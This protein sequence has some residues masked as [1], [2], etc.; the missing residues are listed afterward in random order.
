[1]GTTPPR[2]LIA[3][4]QPDVLE[5]LRLLLK[6]EGYETEAVT[7]PGDVL[8]A[9]KARN[10]DL[11]LM[12]LNYARDTTSGQEGLD[13][14]S[15]VQA[16]DST[17]PVV[18]MT[19]WGSLEVAVEA[20]HR[21]VR[22]FVLKP[23]E[24]NR[25]LDTLRTQ[26]ENGY[27]AREKL[28][29]S[30]EQHQELED[31]LEIQRRLLPKQLPQIG[32]FQISAAWRPARAVSGD[33]FDA[34]KFD[35]SRLALCIA[36][37]SGKGMPAALLM[38]NLQAVVKAFASEAVSPSELC[39]RV[40][41]VVSSNTPDDRFITFLYCLLDSKRRRLTYS[42]AGHNPGIIA[43]GNGEILRLDRGGTV[44]GPFVRCKFEQGEIAVESGD[45]VLLFTDGV[46]EA[47]NEYGEEFGEDRLIGLLTEHR[48]L[49]ADDLQ[50]ALMQAVFEF[51]GGDFHDDATLIVCSVD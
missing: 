36:D 48:G 45:R 27:V 21:G 30:A 41:R 29:R 33:Y 6:G 4:D 1:M 43:R 38:S 8:E 13:L 40:N 39:T 51:S 19:A 22:D 32:G 42:N 24:N 31:A 37:V 11:L 34:L 47:R 5:A 10:F 14:L 46:T 3:D 7:S 49:D 20:M 18:V 9:I 35:E 16:M 15:R 23:W 17:L 25:L 28:R 44:L 26:I 12:D 2:T 50:R